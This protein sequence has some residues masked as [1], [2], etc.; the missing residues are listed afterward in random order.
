MHTLL[1]LE[2]SNQAIKMIK[3]TIGT[4]F[5]SAQWHLKKNKPSVSGDLKVL[6][7]TKIIEILIWYESKSSIWFGKQ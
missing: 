2:S 1:E 3:I 6:D 4:T 5:A 7:V